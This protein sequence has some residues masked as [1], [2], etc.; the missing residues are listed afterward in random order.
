MS[1]DV[2]YGYWSY[3]GKDGLFGAQSTIETL[4]DGRKIRTID[5]DYP[6]VLEDEFILWAV[7]NDKTALQSF[8][9]RLPTMDAVSQVRLNDL[10]AQYPAHFIDRTDHL[11]LS[12]NIQHKQV[13]ATRRDTTRNPYM[14]KPGKPV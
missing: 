10:V 7:K 1:Q 9:A 8:R 6:A 2:P 12:D 3:G 11:T 4:R 13:T 5:P 14:E